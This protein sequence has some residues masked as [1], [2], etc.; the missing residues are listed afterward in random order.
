[1][2][3]SPQ[4]YNELYNTNIS[5]ETFTKSYDIYPYIYHI[6]EVKEIAEGLG[7]DRSVI[8]G[9]IL[10]DTLEDGDLSY[11]DIK[12]AFGFIIAEIVFAVTDELGRNRDERKAK[13]YPKIREKGSHQFQLRYR[14]GFQEL[15]I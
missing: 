1:M 3:I 2:Y 6:K 15:L 10:H 5:I 4:Y 9:A 13:T 12:K 14:T 11:N 7:Y 8:I